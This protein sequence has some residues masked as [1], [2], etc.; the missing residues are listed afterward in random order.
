MRVNSIANVAKGLGLALFLL[1]WLLVVP[2]PSWADWMRDGDRLSVEI[3]QGAVDLTGLGHPQHVGGTFGAVLCCAG[4]IWCSFRAPTMLALPVTPMVVGGGVSLM[5]QRRNS[6]N[7]AAGDSS[8]M[9][10][11]LSAFFYRRFRLR[12]WVYGFLRSDN[13]LRFESA[14]SRLR[15]PGSRPFDGWC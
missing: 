1:C 9:R 14:A 4:A 5:L 7:A 11:D 13:Q 3:K 12:R 15:T 8:S 10:A 6:G 2:Q